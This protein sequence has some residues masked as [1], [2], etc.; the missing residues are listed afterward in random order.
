MSRLLTIAREDVRRAFRSRLVWG[1][2]ALLAVM[3]LPSIG[4]SA[5]PEINP[6]GEFLLL[7]PLDLMT[8]S[9]VVVAA[10]GYGA[11]VAERVSG[12]AQYVLGLPATRR[13]FVLGKLLSRTAIVVAAL[14]VILGIANVLVDQGY[15]R[16]SVL[17]FWVMGGWMLGYVVVWTAVTVGY[18][19][20]F[21]SPYRTLAAL[22]VT[23]VVFS[24]NVGVWRVVVRPLFALLFTGS[25]DPPSY[26]TLATAPLW[27]R[28]TERLNPLSDFWAAMRWSVEAVGPGTPIGGPLPQIAGT[29]V[30][31]LFGAL[32]LLFGLRRFEGT[33]LG[34]ERA[35][36]QLGGTLWR[37]LWGVRGAERSAVSRLRT[38]SSR[39][40]R[41]AT[42][43]CRHSLQN[44]LVVGSLAVTL[45]I[46]GPSL[47][48]AVDASSVFTDVEVLTRVPYSLRFPVLVLGIAVGHDAVVGERTAGTDRLLLGTTV[49]RR[50]IVLG[51]LLSRLGIVFATL[52][53]LLLGAELLV[54]VRFGRPYPGA[55]LA[56]V[57]WTL[58][59]AG[60]WTAATTGIS[61]AVASRYRSLAVVV[62]VYLLFGQLWQ[63]L[64]LPA[65]AFVA[66][67][68][69]SIDAFVRVADPPTWFQ[70]TDHLSP[71]VALGTVREGLFE[72]AGYGT[73]QTALTVPLFL[74]S[75]VVLLVFAGAALVIGERRFDRVDLT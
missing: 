48:T 61:A 68:R 14:V 20:A 9:L 46:A 60:V 7:L 45:L 27:L 55:F 38:R 49:T 24:P 13:D 72:L 37:S 16:A 10:V 56:L 50:E 40:R 54:V 6:L 63:Q 5:R 33:D 39:L 52:S 65:V 15:G 42:A 35:G 41:L 25:L 70:Y 31:L 3:F 67:G 74:Y 75:V 2:V 12:T 47:W 36:F 1:A 26:E 43:D 29:V 34:G 28:V 30:F 21:D 22:V 57:G 62:A 18:S 4:G 69:F 53:V 64:V 71:F 32:P 58:L 59:Y 8:F 23:Y 19:A 73:A 11:V 44:W 66:M 51:K 17:P